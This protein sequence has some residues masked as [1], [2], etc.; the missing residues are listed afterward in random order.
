M[1]VQ[2]YCAGKQVMICDYLH[3][4]FDIKALFILNLGFLVCLL[5]S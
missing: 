4:E 1:Q 5:S 3:Y 2:L